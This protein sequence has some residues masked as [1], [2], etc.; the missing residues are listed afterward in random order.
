MMPNIRLPSWEYKSLSP[1]VTFDERIKIV[2]WIMTGPDNYY[3]KV[4]L[5]AYVNETINKTKILRIEAIHVKNTWGSHCDKL[6]I[7]STKTDIQGKLTSTNRNFLIFLE[8]SKAK[9]NTNF[10]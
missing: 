3:T 7:L 1:K 8:F 4:R 2:C 10:I 6:L 9:N 5:S